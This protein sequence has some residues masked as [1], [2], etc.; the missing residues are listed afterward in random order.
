MRSFL[1][2]PARKKLTSLDE[3]K[4]LSQQISNRNGGN[5]YEGIGPDVENSWNHQE[6]D[7]ANDIDVSRNYVNSKNRNQNDSHSEDAGLNSIVPLGANSQRKKSRGGKPK[8]KRTLK[9][10]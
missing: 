6:E 9:V 2:K 10:E 4:A 3:I 7:T 5:Y 1:D 8:G